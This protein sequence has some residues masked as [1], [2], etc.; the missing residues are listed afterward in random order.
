MYYSQV[1]T[2]LPRFFGNCS[3]PWVNIQLRRDPKNGI[4]GLLITDPKLSVPPAWRESELLW[5]SKAWAAKG[6]NM[7]LS[8][9]D[10]LAFD[11]EGK[12]CNGVLAVPSGA[13]AHIYKN[14]LYIRHPKMWRKDCGFTSNTIAEVQHGEVSI[15]GLEIHARRYDPQGAI[16][17]FISH[18][19][20]TGKGKKKYETHRDHYL[21]GI[22]AYGFM[23]D[24]EWLKLKHPRIYQK[25]P[26]KYLSSRYH[27]WM[28]YTCGEQK[29]HIEFCNDS[30]KDR[31]TLNLRIKRPDLD[32]SW[33]GV[34]KETLAAFMKWLKKIA[35]EE[36]FAKI[37]PDAA[38]R[39]NQGDAFFA[40]AMNIELAAT[41]PGECQPS[42]MSQ[43]LGGGKDDSA[44]K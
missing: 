22:G 1:E 29:W 35:P 28:G 32:E 34:T 5:E 37:D 38:L 42:V 23:S 14:W 3:Q 21:A 11:T 26:S 7:A 19:E 33:L 41:P 43:M 10:I 39:F 16:F 17:C 36:Y 9:W 6:I 30:G 18:T 8:N 27:Q 24:V 15:A 13:E 12:P 44:S 4:I 2:D 31:F 20:Y 40:G 25:I